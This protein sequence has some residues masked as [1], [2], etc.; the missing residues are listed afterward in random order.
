[1]SSP[2]DTSSPQ[3]PIPSSPLRPGGTFAKWFQYITD[4]IAGMSPAGEPYSTNWI[5]GPEKV[6][7]VISLGSNWDCDAFAISRDGKDIDMCLYLTYTGPPIGVP[8]N[9]DIANTPIGVMVEGWL[10]RYRASLTS[11]H[12]GPL[13]AASVDFNG[14]LSLN[15]VAPGTQIISGSKFSFQGMWRLKGIDVA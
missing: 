11:C 3:A 15:S 8:A 7:Q 12:D 5:A 6:G 10:P 2:S 14:A 4:W 1:M 9:G 13:A